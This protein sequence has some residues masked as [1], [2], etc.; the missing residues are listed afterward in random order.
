[1]TRLRVVIFE[2]EPFIAMEIK[3]AVEDAG[4]SVS[5][6][7]R[8]SS[9]AHAI[10]EEIKPDLAIVDLNLIDGD[11]GSDLASFLYDRGCEIVVY[12]ASGAVDPALCRISHT[13]IRKPLA[14]ELL[15]EALRGSTGTESAG[16]VTQ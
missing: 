4:C 13:F 6:V 5:G 11:T 2:D 16:S 15:R 10:I 12:S 9:S 3:D 8:D 14:P 7:F 1:M